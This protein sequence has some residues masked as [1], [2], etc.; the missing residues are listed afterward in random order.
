M[1]LLIPSFYFFTLIGDYLDLVRTSSHWRKK[2][3]R[4]RSSWRS[5]TDVFKQVISAQ[6][7]LGYIVTDLPIIVAGSNEGGIITDWMDYGRLASGVPTIVFTGV[8]ANTATTY[9][10]LSVIP[11][12]PWLRWYITQPYPL[13][14]PNPK[15]QHRPK[16][17][18]HTPLFHKL[19]PFQ[20]NSH[21]RNMKSLPLH[22]P[23]QLNIIHNNLLL[24]NLLQRA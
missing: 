12:C 17:P 18:P 20:N 3:V 23:C 21:R 2:S 13:F 6:V 8:A 1:S 16:P 24:H 7:A 5:A 11:S 4:S 10:A 15:P 9:E 19:Q 22:D 14:H